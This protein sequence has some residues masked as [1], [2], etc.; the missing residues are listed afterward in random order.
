MGLCLTE[1]AIAVNVA[2][3]LW[4]QGEANTNNPPKYNCLFPSAITDWREFWGA[5]GANSR[6][7]QVTVWLTFGPS[8]VH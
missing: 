1:L 4:D 5:P 3:M 7:F 8:L 6:H 2:G